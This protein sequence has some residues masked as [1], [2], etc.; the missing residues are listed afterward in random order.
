MV[1]EWGMSPLGTMVYGQKDEMIFLGRDMMAHNEYSEETARR[2]D[3]EVKKIIDSAYEKA[4]GII[5]EHREELESI[6]LLLLEKESLNSEEIQ[7][8][9]HGKAHQVNHSPDIP[10]KRKRSVEPSAA[11]AKSKKKPA[12]TETDS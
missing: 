12:P 8:V 5:Q 11:K 9:L 3:Q 10:E 1:C 6:A 7:L 4:R 2:I